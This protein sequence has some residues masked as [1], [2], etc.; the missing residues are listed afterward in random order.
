MANS[1]VITLFLVGLLVYVGLLML[2]LRKVSHDERFPVG[3]IIFVGGIIAA[4]PT[5]L[6]KVGV[7]EQTSGAVL[8]AFLYFFVLMMGSVTLSTKANKRDQR[9][10][11]SN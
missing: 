4:L 7:V 8:I 1:I 10:P 3:G 9:K 6:I 11:G 5:I 2:A